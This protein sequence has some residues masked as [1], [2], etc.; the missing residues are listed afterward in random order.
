MRGRPNSIL[1][2]ALGAFA[3]AV[4]F[5][6]YTRSAWEDWYI[7]YRAARNL[8]LGDG[9][10]FNPGERVH[11]FTSPIGTLLPAAFRWL[12]GSDEAALWCFRAAGAAALAAS[13]PLLARAARIAGLAGLPLGALLT[14][15]A[16]DVKTVAFSVNGQETGFMILFLTVSLEALWAGGPRAPLRLGAALAGLQWTR[17]DGF[18]YGG[19]ALLG[20]LLFQRR[21]AEPAAAW[22]PRRVGTAAVVA[23][24]LYAPW[25]AFT[26]SFYGT[27][28][29][30]SAAA[31]AVAL[32]RDSLAWAMNFVVY[33][34]RLLGLSADGDP[35]FMP[36][37][38]SGGWPQPLILALSLI[39]LPAAAAWAL[40]LRRPLVRAASFAFLGAHFYLRMV[41]PGYPWYFPAAALLGYLAFAGLL[42][43]LI[44]RAPAAFRFGALT[45]LV[46]LPLASAAVTIGSAWQLRLQ[47]QIVE[48]GNRKRIG[49]WLREHAAPGDTVFLEPLG[50]IGF[51]SNLKT[52]DFPGMS[53]PEVVAARRR[54]GGPPDPRSWPALIR[55][56]RPVWLVLR[57]S[58]AETVRRIDP[59][60]LEEAYGPAET[61][62]VTN[63][64]REVGYVPGAG[65]LWMDSVFS[66]F[67]RKVEPD[68][69]R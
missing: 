63:R 26:L 27:P 8:A 55:E 51:Y 5:A 47:Q 14:L 42:A 64:I 29:P 44:E 40:P 23:A 10:V 12:T 58:E 17:P 4:L 19:A 65:L 60:L 36:V 57:P 37:Y 15:V 21:R 59:A 22:S 30:H 16:V 31:K 1:L 20:T 43:E 2:A 18:V 24:A 54:L 46:A 32:S 66:V 67:R 62:D 49:L 7:T 53:S 11:T 3:L 69:T 28:V 6:L 35:T 48:E 45:L 68:E 50:Y 25:L 33:P 38:G 52:Y 13:I 34:R 39:A 56:L 41:S 61:F 9:L